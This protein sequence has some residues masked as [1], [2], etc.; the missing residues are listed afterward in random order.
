MIDSKTIPIAQAAQLGDSFTKFYEALRASQ[1]NEQFH[2][3]N[4]SKLQQQIQVCTL[5]LEYQLLYVDDLIATHDLSDG[6]LFEY[7]YYEV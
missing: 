7:F 6:S 1:R 3:E 2:L 5:L 4:A